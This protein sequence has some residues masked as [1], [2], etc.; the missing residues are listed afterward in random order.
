MLNRS[1][2]QNQNTTLTDAATTE[3]EEDA[4]EALLKLG[5]DMNLEQIDDNSTLMPIGGSGKNIATN[6]VPVPIKLSAKDVQEA[7][8]NLQNGNA[9]ITD[10][11]NNDAHGMKTQSPSGKNDGTVENISPPTLPPTLPPK[12]KLEFKE[13]GI[14]KKD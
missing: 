14:K 13:Y 7:V 11:N 5:D 3:D 1:T 10:N 12:G 6:V 9:A 8:K 4:A 2:D